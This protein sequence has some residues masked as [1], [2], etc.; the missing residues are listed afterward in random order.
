MRL[1]PPLGALLPVL[2]VL[3]PAGVLNPL[4]A[5]ELVHLD[6]EVVGGVVESLVAVHHVH[7]L[8]NGKICLN[9]VGI[10]KVLFMLVENQRLV[11]IFLY[12]VFS[13]LCFFEYCLRLS[14]NWCPLILRILPCTL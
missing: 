6:E 2:L 9:Y 8:E 14:Y 12:T 3:D 11:N 7:H 4:L 10:V 13:A 1:S 5:L